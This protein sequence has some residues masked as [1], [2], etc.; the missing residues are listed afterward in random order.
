MFRE[1]LRFVIRNLARFAYTIIFSLALTVVF[2]IADDDRSRAVAANQSV[3]KAVRIGGDIHRTRFVMD[4]SDKVP[5]RLF[6]LADHYRVVVDMPNV[7]F[8]LPKGA[9]RKGRGLIKAYRFGLF[10]PGK[11]R[12]VI[13]VTR[14]VL[15]DKVF[16]LPAQNGQPSRLVID[17]TPTNR[18]TFLAK[19]KETRKSQSNMFQNNVAAKKTVQLKSAPRRSGKSVVKKTKL[20]LVVI[21][22]GHGGID[23]GAI[24]VGGTNEKDIVLRFAKLLK[25]EL[26]RRG[27]VRVKMSRSKDVFVPL[28][29]RVSFARTHAADLFV[30]IHADSIAKRR[31][32]GVRGASVYTLSEEASDLEAAALAEK[33]NRSDIIAGVEL[34][35]PTSDVPQILIDLAQRE[36]KNYSV[37]FANMVVGE[38]KGSALIKRDPIRSANFRVLTA[39][40]VPSV[41]VELGYLS[42]R[43]DEKLLKSHKWRTKVAVSLVKAIEDY[44][45]KRKLNRLPMLLDENLGKLTASGR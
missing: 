16:V 26:G 8:K 5:F 25:K 2:A 3:A 17:L 12:I 14:P 6:T 42:S 32:K 27:H 4:L 21:D 29:E 7:R 31:A 41:L 19:L 22:P 37:V 33:E 43:A 11:S 45:A 18:Q 13:D 1:M 36:T 23:A 34:P 40:D 15:I 10:A 9:G 20:P 35:P 30:S 24:G 28:P 38:M 39:P 44:F